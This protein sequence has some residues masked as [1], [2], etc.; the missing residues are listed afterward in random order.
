[1]KTHG[2]LTIINPADKK[3]YRLN[4]KGE[5]GELKV[6]QLKQCLATAA[7]CPIPA[8]N[9]VIK[10]CGIPLDR[11]EE[12]CAAY[13]ITDGSTL[14]VEAQNN[15]GPAA[16][17]TVPTTTFPYKRAPEYQTIR[18]QEVG[19][20]NETAVCESVLQEKFDKLQERLQAAGQKKMD[21]V[22]ETEKAQ[23]ELKKIREEEELVQ[24]E[25][26]RLAQLRQEETQRAA[27]RAAD[28]AARREQLQA[29]EAAARAVAL[30]KLDNERRRMLLEKQR[31]EYMA[32]KQCLQREREAYERRA[33]EREIAIRAK[34][35]DIE[36]KI[37]AAERDRKEVEMSRLISQKNRALYF[38]RMGKS[39]P[40][41][42]MQTEP[43]EN[44][45]ADGCPL[46]S[47][48][49]EQLDGSNTVWKKGQGMHSRFSQQPPGLVKSEGNTPASG[50]VNYSLQ[51]E[52]SLAGAGN[53]VTTMTTAQGKTD[54]SFSPEGGVYDAHDNAMKNLIYLGKEFGLKDPLVFDNN[55]TCVI[56]VDGEDTLLVTF[57]AATER[58]Y[59]YSTLL[60]RIPKD[61]N[62]RLQLY[63]FLMEGAL[64]GREMCGGGVGASIKNDFVILSTSIYLPTSLSTTLGIL[65][66]NFLMTVNRWRE[67]LQEFLA[68]RESKE[69]TFPS[70][71]RDTSTEGAD[72]VET[73]HLS[74]T[75]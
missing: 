65:A 20:G 59:M 69:E 34:E 33:K 17:H 60:R 19:F 57:D 61:P 3:R 70:K 26:Q 14:T 13:G 16:D 41:E 54:N 15:M 40:P 36:H 29:E 55:N 7:S 63:D 23:W 6:G 21:L 58:L 74:V 68:G 2:V 18:N 75:Q 42:L 37:L 44:S 71:N 49:V 8:A 51:D 48:P 56:G 43:M 27:R 11:N 50:Y 30:Q 53:N 72:E 31:E 9:Q 39:V 4:I 22:W 32:A 64:L 28:L 24:R 5:I 1:M 12:V 66:P 25:K 35:I 47:L 46:T 10:L 45:W 67:R 52:S 62:I 38:N 73:R